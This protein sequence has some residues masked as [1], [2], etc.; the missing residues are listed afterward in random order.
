MHV[1]PIAA[2]MRATDRRE[3]EALGRAP[4]QALRT[5]LRTSVHALTAL[6]PEGVPLAMMGVC[7]TGLL[8]G[9]GSPWFLGRDEVFDYGRDLMQRGPRIIA[10]WHETFEVMENIVSVENAKA[11]ALLKRWGAAIG[12]ETVTNRGVAFVPFRFAAAIQGGAAS[13]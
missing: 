13:E 7:S 6:S 2:N 4:K 5:S 12:G 8:S 3:C 1:G 10:W 9:R 11:V